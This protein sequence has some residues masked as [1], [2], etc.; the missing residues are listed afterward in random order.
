MIDEK[1]IELLRKTFLKNPSYLNIL[2]DKSPYGILIVDNNKKILYF[3]QKAEE[4]TGYN[5]K[6]VIGNR[7]LML[8]ICTSCQN[9]C[10]LFDITEENACRKNLELL[11]KDGNAILI[12]KNI[13]PILNQYAQQIG[14]IEFF[15]DK[16]FHDNEKI[17]IQELKKT[18]SMITIFNKELLE[19]STLGIIK[20]DQF[21]K[22]TFANKKASY[23][24]G[25][26]IEDLL[27]GD[28]YSL[29]KQFLKHIFESV[30]KKIRFKFKDKNLELTSI[31]NNNEEILFF[32]FQSIIENLEHSYCNMISNSSKMK[33][34]FNLIENLKDSS[35]NVLIEGDSGT[36]KE[37]IAKA[38]Y[39][40]NNKYNNTFQTINCA[41][42]SSEL[43]ESELFGH[44]KGAFTGAI[45]DKDGKFKLANGGTIFLDEIGELPLNLQAK[46][47]RVLQFKEFDPVGGVNTIKVDVRII[48]ATNKNLQVAIDNKTFRKD[49]YY[50]L[51][52]VPIYLPSL[53]NRKED[54]SLLINYFINNS[55]DNRKLVIV[56]DALNILTEYHWPGNIRELEN[57]ISYLFAVTNKEV[58][59]VDDLPTY[60]TQ[61]NITKKQQSKTE[62]FIHSEKER[63]IEVLSRN[64][65]NQNKTAEEL[66]MHRTTLWRKI[67]KY[68]ISL[69]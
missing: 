46:L 60:I 16:T 40:T 47:L 33:K 67:K 39:T 43:L 25:V 59:E 13:Y 19:N 10:S 11:K 54:I 2:L 32:K 21:R 65:F 48:A 45:S 9:R 23:I 66:N 38:L 30:N 24:L 35:V 52:V 63:I 12:E 50:R 49:L 69:I 8:D 57:L 6:L 3:N 36:G 22:I 37:L 61:L 26:K 1:L 27:K 53:K 55:P 5:Q 17:K 56:P 41:T 29:D 28:I 68:N 58:I 51:K 15:I 62:A 14:A 31:I 18:L 4:L 34:I 42:L 44:V 64:N 20:L 7:C